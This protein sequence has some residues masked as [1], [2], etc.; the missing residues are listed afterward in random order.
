M[1]RG[2][3]EMR[4]ESVDQTVRDAADLVL[5]GTGQ[6]HIRVSYELDPEAPYI[7]A[8]RIQV[9]QVLVNLL[10]NSMEA[11]RSSGRDDRHITISSHRLSDQMSELTVSDTGP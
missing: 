5:V 3:V 2:E 6:F 8:D 7:F 9:Q 11:L 10:R 1:A 4:T